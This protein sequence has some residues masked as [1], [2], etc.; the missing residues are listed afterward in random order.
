MSGMS[1]RW[2]ASFRMKRSDVTDNDVISLI[3][4]IDIRSF[5]VNR[6]KKLE[7]S[8]HNSLIF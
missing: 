3:P 8:I 6:V 7:K 1:T 2:A 4:Q 5:V